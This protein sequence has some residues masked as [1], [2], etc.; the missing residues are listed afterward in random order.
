MGIVD[1]QGD[2]DPQSAEHGPSA[3]PGALGELE[4]KLGV[5]LEH[6]RSV[7]GRPH[8]DLPARVRRL[9]GLVE[10]VVSLI[11]QRLDELPGSGEHGELD[12]SIVRLRSMCQACLSAAARLD[13]EFRRCTAEAMNFSEEAQGMA[14]RLFAQLEQLP[15]RISDPLMQAFTPVRRGSDGDTLGAGPEVVDQLRQLHGTVFRI[16]GFSDVDRA[17]T[18][19]YEYAQHAYEHLSAR[20]EKAS[21]MTAAFLQ[22]AENVLSALDARERPAQTTSEPNR[23]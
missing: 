17:I 11:C 3:A 13:D 15:P 10:E 20:A 16:G 9:A 1:L 7:K 6:V 14:V 21:D 5:A 23:S 19:F 8:E 22:D 2:L 4:D 12:D 18:R